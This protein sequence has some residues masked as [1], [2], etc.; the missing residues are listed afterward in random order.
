MIVNGIRGCCRDLSCSELDSGDSDTPALSYYSYTRTRTRTSFRLPSYTPLPTATNGDVYGYY[1][2]TWTYYYYY[3]F[4]TTIRPSLTA[5][6]S[7]E[8]TTTTT[9][10]VYASNSAEASGQFDSLTLAASV[11]TAVTAPGYEDVATPTSAP[12]STPTP[13]GSSGVR[14]GGEASRAVMGFELGGFGTV[15]LAGGFGVGIGVLAV[16]I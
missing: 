6:T 15:L 1:T 9:V 13:T 3:Y 5:P 11:P 2:Y 12:T 4:I 14:S 8:R 10:S 7:T 16:W